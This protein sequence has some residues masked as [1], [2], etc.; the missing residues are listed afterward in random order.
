[1]LLVSAHL[2]HLSLYKFSLTFISFHFCPD[3]KL[4][5]TVSPLLKY[6]TSISQFSFLIL[7]RNNLTGPTW[8]WSP[9][10]LVMWPS[11]IPVSTLRESVRWQRGHGFQR[12]LS[13][14]QPQNVITTITEQTGERTHHPVPSLTYKWGNLGW[15]RETQGHT[16][17]W[18][19]EPS[20]LNCTC[21][22]HAIWCC[23]F[24]ETLRVP[25]MKQLAFWNAPCPSGSACWEQAA[26]LCTMGRGA[27]FPP[28]CQQWNG[29]HNLTFFRSRI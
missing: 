4:Y 7:K 15:G 20:L 29:R 2:L 21:L 25:S 14:Q 9:P 13:V 5:M 27:A 17:K 18:R 1:M 24:K 12:R 10:L 6:P 23:L 22:F 19:V 3:F 28:G 8:V 11:E 26:L 16:A